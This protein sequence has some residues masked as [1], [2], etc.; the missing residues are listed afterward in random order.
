MTSDL[1]LRYANRCRNELQVFIIDIDDTAFELISC[2]ILSFPSK[3]TEKIVFCFD[4]CPVLSLEKFV[5]VWF[6]FFPI[7]AEVGKRN[8]GKI[9]R[10][11][12]NAEAEKCFRGS[13]FLLR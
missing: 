7:F 11:R 9:F 1:P 5:H 6:E 12:G 2:L 13:F 4:I 3:F 10:G 8:Q